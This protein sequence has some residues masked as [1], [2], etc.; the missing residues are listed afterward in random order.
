MH[1]LVRSVLVFCLL[2]PAIPAQ[3]LTVKLMTWGDTTT[4]AKYAILEAAFEAANPDIDFLR[5]VDS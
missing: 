1:T 4:I 2:A 3:Q 5:T